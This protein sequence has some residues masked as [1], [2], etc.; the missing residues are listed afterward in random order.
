MKALVYTGRS[1]IEFRDV[2]DPVPLDGEVLVRVEAVGICGSDMH[3]YH[4]HDERRPAPLVLGHEA[5][6]IIVGGARAGQRVAVNPLVTCGRCEY[7]LDGRS[8]LCPTR[9]IISMPPRPGAFAELT[10]IP[11]NNAVELPAGMSMTTAALAEPVAVAWHAVRNGVGLLRRPLAG[12]RCA[13]LGG[14]AIGLAAALVL[15]HFGA[16]DVWVAEPNAGRR[17]TAGTAGALQAYAPAADGACPDATAHLVIDA[18]GSDATRGSACR[19]ARPGAVIVH[20]G[21]LPG[22][23][24]L[25]VRRIT[26]QEITLVGCYCYTHVDFIETV[27]AL[28]AGRLGPLAWVEERPFAEGVQAFRDL[29]AGR[30]SAAKIA[31]LLPARA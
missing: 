16:K 30:V 15:L 22:Q 20:V 24:G 4:G 21:L 9:Q 1:Q 19:L 3:A 2:A 13:V 18:V 29:D 27:A 12:A 8:H 10:R 26:L 23:E 25:D 5:A 28:A 14:G 11:A 17:A 31:L 7:C 6:G